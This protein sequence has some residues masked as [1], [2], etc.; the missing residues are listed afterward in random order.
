MHDINVNLQFNITQNQRN[1]LFTRI[2]IQ[3]Q[4]LLNL[5]SCA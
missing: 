2:D 4:F 3:N 5:L 1:E